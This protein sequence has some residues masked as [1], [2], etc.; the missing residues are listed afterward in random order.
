MEI[1]STLRVA[2]SALTRNKRRTALTMLGITIGIG[3]VIC[4]VALGQGGSDQVQEQLKALGDNM[5]LIQSGNVNF[6]GV[7][8][9]T[10]GTK[11]LTIEDAAAIAQSVPQVKAVSPNVDSNSQIVYGNMNWNTTYRGVSPEYLSIANWQIDS[12]ANF[13]QQD[14]DRLNDVCLIGQTIA[15]NL[16]GNDDPV[17]KTMRV[18]KLPF[19]VIGVLKSKGLSTYGRDQDDFIVMPIST[20]MK[21]LKGQWWLDDIFLSVDDS[22]HITAADDEISRLLRQRHHLRRGQADDFIIRSPQDLLAAR[23]QTAEEFTFMLGSIASVS[24]LVGGIGIMNIMLVS[25]TERTRE[26]GVRMAV[27]ATENDVQMQFLIE[28]VLVSM[29]GGTIG[30]LVGVLASLGFAKAL[31]WRMSVSL[32]A[33]VIAA[34]FSIGIGVFFGYYPA[35]KASLLDPIVALRYE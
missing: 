34:L 28:S 18:G 26:I 27:G 7:R 13:S 1:K 10:G 30:V 3:A 24:L 29:L 8:T 32:E 17:G 12:G 31:D 20:A 6:G 25:V 33:I 15:T 22:D 16:F 2:L 19:Q 9:G 5:V 21:K 35:K 4:T 23:E 11:S 14:V